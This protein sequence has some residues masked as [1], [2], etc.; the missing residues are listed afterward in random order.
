MTVATLQCPWCKQWHTISAPRNTCPS[1]GH[2]IDVSPPFCD[3]VQCKIRR[4][5]ELSGQ[6]NERQTAE[7]RMDA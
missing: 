7:R 3:C 2:R 4:D 6:I 1:C 5:A